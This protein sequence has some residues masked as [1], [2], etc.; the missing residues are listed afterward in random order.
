MADSVISLEVLIENAEGAKTIGE[1]KKSVKDLT[2]AALEAEKSGNKILSD[3]FITAAGKAKAELKDLKEKIN[4]LDP[5]KKAAAFGK[6]T[7]TLAGGFE[8]AIASSALFGSKNE[9]LEKTL[10]KVQAAMA[11]S[12]GVQELSEIGKAFEAFNLIV[13]ANPILFIVAAFTTLAA[14]V[15]AYSDTLFGVRDIEKES[16]EMAK[17]EA[18]LSAQKVKDMD[19]EVLNMKL[20]HKSAKEILAFQIETVKVAIEKNE[21]ELIAQEDLKKKQIETAERNN[22]IYSGIINF[23]SAPLVLILKGVDKLINFFGGAS[24]LAGDYTKAVDNMFFSPEKVKEDAEKELNATREKNKALTKQYTQYQLDL[25]NI[26][27]ESSKKVYEEKNKAH[28]EYLKR[29]KDADTA[30]FEDGLRIEKE[31]LAEKEKLEKE[32]LDKEIQMHSSFTQAI[33][34]DPVK[35]KKE[36]EESARR[37]QIQKNYFDSAVALSGLLFEMR[38]NHVKKGSAEEKKILKQQFEIN[39]LVSASTATINGIQSVTKTLAEG[40]PLAIPLAA[41]MGVLAAINVAKILAT[42]FDGGGGGADTGGNFT[43]GGVGGNGVQLN[44][45]GS[46]QTLLGPDGKPLGNQGS[47]QPIKAYVVETDITQSQKTIKSIESKAQF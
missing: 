31:K 27:E 30:Y 6:L 38:L 19:Q 23:I 21:L 12:R 39:K 41:S 24:N 47:N 7:R 9:E 28:E 8:A 29:I 26:S 17:K 11:L 36:Q 32:S 33:V 5:E 20:N 44:P 35:R 40:G 46:N 1:L 2:N 14:I 3:Q 13:K 22:K 37:L 10:L 18:E 34:D 16:L 45:V 43:G 4:A 15:T 25:Q 42:K